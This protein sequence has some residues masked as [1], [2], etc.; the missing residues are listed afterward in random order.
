MEPV[1]KAS[2]T[3]QEFRIFNDTRQKDGK[4]SNSPY[5]AE[6][7]YTNFR[8]FMVFKDWQL[9]ECIFTGSN[10][11]HE[12]NNISHQL[13][14][15]MEYRSQKPAVS[16]TVKGTLYFTPD[17]YY[18]KRQTTTSLERKIGHENGYDI[19]YLDNICYYHAETD[20]DGAIRE[21][22]NKYSLAICCAKDIPPA[23]ITPRIMVL[24]FFFHTSEKVKSLNSSA[25]ILFPVLAT[26]KS[27]P[28]STQPVQT[29]VPKKIKPLV[30]LPAKR[31][32]CRYIPPEVVPS[33]YDAG[34]ISYYHDEFKGVKYDRRC[35]CEISGWDEDSGR[36]RSNI[37]MSDSSFDNESK[38]SPA[39]IL[40]NRNTFS[41]LSKGKEEIDS[42][43]INNNNT[44][45]PN[46]T[47]L[48]C[49]CYTHAKFLQFCFRLA[50]DYHNISMNDIHAYMLWDSDKLPE[51]PS[52]KRYAKMY[53]PNPEWKQEDSIQG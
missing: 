32:H 14:D 5:V 7:I 11:G 8:D 13:P 16:V 48:G 44:N 30:K 24:N 34:S 1:G 50:A 15:V 2:T 41:L 38:S 19:S 52:E 46:S 25:R 39:Y 40:V 33:R 31:V 42:I 21:I 10:R 35:I 18:A 23:F 45:E 26:E 49:I 4:I 12:C 29:V 27:E 17:E 20:L 37:G 53:M 47:V 9:N 36:C 6:E 51:Y 43:I 22:Y 28:T 3:R